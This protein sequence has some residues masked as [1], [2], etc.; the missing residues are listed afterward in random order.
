MT[1]IMFASTIH[2]TKGRS[3][4][5][6]FSLF[7]SLEPCSQKSVEVCESVS[8]LDICIINFFSFTSDLILLI[9][10]EWY[11]LHELMYVSCM[12]TLL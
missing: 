11:L 3:L 12:M 6:L 10:N 4:K 8:L 2:L 7:T 1:N 9:L 5:V